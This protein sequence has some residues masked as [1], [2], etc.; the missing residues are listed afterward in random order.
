MRIAHLYNIDATA[1]FLVACFHSI[2]PTVFPI[3]HL[4]I[5]PLAAIN[6]K[7]SIA[8]HIFFIN[9][10]LRT[11]LHQ[12]TSQVTTLVCSIK[13]H[14]IRSCQFELTTGI[15]FRTI[16][17]FL[18]HT[19]GKSTVYTKSYSIPQFTAII[20]PHRDFKQIFTIGIIQFTQVHPIP[21]TCK[22]GSYRVCIIIDDSGK[23]FLC[24]FIHLMTFFI[25]A[26][27]SRI[28]RI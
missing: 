24:Q 18:R 14:I 4:T 5:V 8:K 2:P 10:T 19:T 17:M 28:S 12:G 9:A 22:S 6:G 16:V 3:F 13:R 20:Q 1:H 23:M 25:I 27:L 15:T 21:I 11:N 26:T 7:R